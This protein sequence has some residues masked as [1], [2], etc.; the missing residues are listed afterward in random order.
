MVEFCDEVNLSY[1]EGTVVCFIPPGIFTETVVLP[2]NTV[3]V[4]QR[5]NRGFSCHFT[6]VVDPDPVD[7]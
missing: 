6:S 3:S 4:Q 2:K 5:Q 1:H 7:P